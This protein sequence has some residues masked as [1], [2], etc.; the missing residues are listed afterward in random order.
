MK[1]FWTARYK[2][3]EI[4]IESRWFRGK[5]Y[6][7]GELMDQKTRFLSFD[8]SGYVRDNKGKKHLIKAY[9]TGPIS[10]SCSLY[11]NG[12]KVKVLSS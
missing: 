6:V 11:V 7:N 10:I 9:V 4:S 3:Y 8:L 12:E 1:S 2:E 5:M